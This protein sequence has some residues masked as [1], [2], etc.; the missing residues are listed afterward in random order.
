MELSLVIDTDTAS[1]DAVA[2]IIAARTPGTK[3][4]AVT[5][6]AGNVPLGYGVR[7]ALGTLALLGRDEVAVHA[8]LDAPLL[9]PLETAQVVHGE[10]GMSGVE[11]PEA[12][13][14]VEDEHAVDFLRR[15]ARDEPG[16]HTL[17]ALGPLSNI[18]TALLLDPDLLTRFRHTYMMAGAADGIGNVHRVGEYNVWADPEAASIVF[19]APGDKTMIGWDVSRASAVMSP[20]EQQRMSGSGAL[21]RFVS[22]INRAT[23]EFSRAHS[24]LGGYVL[25]DPL[26]MAI[27]LDPT[28]AT[29]TSTHHVTIGLDDRT[30]GGTFVDHRDNAPGPNV[31][32]VWAVDEPRFKDLLFRS[33]TG[34]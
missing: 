8:G 7:N 25:P 14:T 27:A 2:L 32:V 29:R 21:G 15:V 11:V 26:A 31:H 28:I 9:R 3:I 16:T 13:R 18:A 12:R 4:R 24:D 5:V 30:R 33:C 34:A 17:V 20:D 19:D 22:D 1:D 23:D 6:V 10:N